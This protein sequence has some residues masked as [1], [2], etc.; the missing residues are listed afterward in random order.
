[1]IIEPPHWI[2]P[3]IEEMIMEAK[4]KWP[5]RFKLETLEGQ[6]YLILNIHNDHFESFNIWDKIKIAEGVNELCQ[7]IGATGCPTYVRKM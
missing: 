6:H 5:S 2:T 3:E 1:M 4:A 7:K